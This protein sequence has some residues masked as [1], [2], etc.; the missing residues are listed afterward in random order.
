MNQPHAE[1]G[2]DPRMVRRDAD[3]LNTGPPLALRA[4]TAVTPASLFFTRSHAAVPRVDQAAWRLR[5]TGMV[6]QPLEFSFEELHTRFPRVSRTASLVCAGL[7]RDELIATRPIP[8]EL[9]WGSDPI[10]TGVWSG[11]A[12]GALLR[13]AEPIAG[14]SCVAFLGVDRVERHGATF[15]FGGSVPLAKA[16][17]DEALLASELNGAPL[18]PAHGFPL[19]GLIPGYIGA[20]SVKWLA[21]ITVQDHPSDNYFQ[22]HAYRVLREPDPA[23]P[24]DVTSG[25]PL[26]AIALNSVMLSPPQGAQVAAGQVPIAGWALGG[27]GAAIA[28][29]ELSVDDGGSWMAAELDRSAGPWGWTLWRASPQLTPGSQTVIVRAFDDRGGSQPADLAEVWNAKGYANSAW[30]RVSFT[31]V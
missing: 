27:D 17:A 1:Q 24:R 10:S 23:D 29:V 9:P 19:R 2:K 13:A 12:L 22:A 26:S 8:G 15:G 14:A 6:R 3:G 28:R 4:A 30:H 25:T 5:V 21:E 18:L 16:L 11:V 7:R 31:A 20:R